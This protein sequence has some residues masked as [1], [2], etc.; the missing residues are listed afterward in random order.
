MSQ[1]GVENPDVAV[2]F[3]GGASGLRYLIESDP[4]YGDEYDVVCAF[5]DNP[6]ATGAGFVRDKGIPLLHNDI[7]EFYEERDADI[8]DLDVRSEFDRE[9]LELIEPH[10]P[11][12]IVLSGYMRILTDPVVEEYPIIN[13]HPADLRKEDED[14]ER[15][16]TGFDPVYDAVVAGQPYTRS[17]THLVTSDVDDGP[18]IAVS[19][20]FKVHRELVD[21]L[22]ERDALESVRDYSDS[23]QEWMKWQG[24]GPAL[25]KSLELVSDGRVDLEDGEIEVDGEKGPFVM[26]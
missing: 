2:F 11:D 8:R 4:G 7:E 19:R 23:H 6:Q 25:A 18:L 17:S 10:D 14:G 15:I 12:L 21:P 1:L 13:V 24:D 26:G 5:T 3:S 16:Y 22:V 20:P 9:T